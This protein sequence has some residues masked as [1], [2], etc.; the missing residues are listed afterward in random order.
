ML[1]ARPPFIPLLR[2]LDERAPA[3][4]IVP[5][6]ITCAA[7]ARNGTPDIALTL[8]ALPSKDAADRAAGAFCADP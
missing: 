8:Q 1:P 2:R 4:P 6:G 5:S 7:P 3:T